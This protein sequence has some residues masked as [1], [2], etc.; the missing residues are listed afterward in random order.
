MTDSTGR[1]VWTAEYDPFGK[2]TVN[3]DPD[4]DGKAVVNNLRFPGQY[5]DAE[6]G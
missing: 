1:I 5:F 6:A 2:A 3:E 4:G